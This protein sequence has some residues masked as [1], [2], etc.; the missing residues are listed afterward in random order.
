MKEK[1]ELKNLKIKSFVTSEKS[2]VRG[3]MMQELSDQ[4][5]CHVEKTAWDV[6]PA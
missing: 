6:C 5:W 4:N 2:Q 3:G 1:I